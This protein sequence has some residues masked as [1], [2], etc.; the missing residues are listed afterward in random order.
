MWL[1]FD[2]GF[3]SV[4]SKPGEEDLCVR[5]RRAGDIEAMRVFCPEL[6]PASATEATDYPVRAWVPREALARAV[7]R[8]AMSIDYGNFKARVAS[9]QGKARA[10]IYGDVWAALRRLEA[11]DRP[12]VG[13][14]RP[15]VPRKRRPGGRRGA[16]GGEAG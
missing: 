10:A 16:G 7:G 4:V 13:R 12:P 5:A 2:G 15:A 8:V 3:V 11:E 9:R 6:S 14:S 1:I